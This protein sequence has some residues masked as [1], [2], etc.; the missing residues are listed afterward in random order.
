M[1]RVDRKRYMKYVV[2]ELNGPIEPIMFTNSILGNYSFH[3]CNTKT[4]FGDFHVETVEETLTH[5]QLEIPSYNPTDD[6]SCIIVDDR[7]NFL[8]SSS[9]DVALDVIFWKLYFDDSNC[10]EG[11]GAGSIL[12]DPQGSQHLMANRLDFA[13]T[14]N[15]DE[16]EGL[17]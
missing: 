11:V 7:T 13:C 1:L 14:N 8:D 17:L 9:I 3:V 15:I 5:T 2:T 4:C 16:Y 12:I 6:L 10:F